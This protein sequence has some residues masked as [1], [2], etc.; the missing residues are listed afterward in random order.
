[1]TP[2]NE[3]FPGDLVTVTGNV[4][5]KLVTFS[6][7]VSAWDRYFVSPRSMNRLW[8]SKGIVDADT[9]LCSVIAVAQ[10]NKLSLENDRNEQFIAFGFKVSDAPAALLLCHSVVNT[11]DE[12]LMS[13]VRPDDD[14]KKRFGS[15]PLIL[16]I[17][18]PLTAGVTRVSC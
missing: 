4:K 11:S 12:H 14:R 3:L 18:H 9:F 10:L 16:L 5:E 7:H 2:V 13:N 1:M 6:V 8:M 17:D 15:L